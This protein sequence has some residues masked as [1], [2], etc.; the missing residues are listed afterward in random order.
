MISSGLKSGDGFNRAQTTKAVSSKEVKRF[1]FSTIREVPTYQAFLIFQVGWLSLNSSATSWAIVLGYVSTN[2]LNWSRPMD[3]HVLPHLQ[4]L[5]LHLWILHIYG[6]IY[7]GTI[8]A[9]TVYKSYLAFIFDRYES[10]VDVAWRLRFIYIFLE[11][12]RPGLNPISPLSAKTYTQKT[13][14]AFLY[15]ENIWFTWQHRVFHSLIKRI[16]PGI[17]SCFMSCLAWSSFEFNKS[18][19]GT[20]QDCMHRCW[21]SGWYKSRRFKIYLSLPAIT[22]LLLR[23]RANLNNF[24]FNFRTNMN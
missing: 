12:L 3:H 4:G 23:Y 24:F 14:S 2:L 16:Y 17:W 13:G 20:T 11:K 7:F 9:K 21:W 19:D 1:W 8:K 6:T 22:Q 10:F 18:S 15:L 5:H